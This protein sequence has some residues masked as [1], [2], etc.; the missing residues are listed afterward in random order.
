LERV[1]ERADLLSM[2]DLYFDD[3][4]RLNLEIERLRAVSSEDV[5]R[6]AGERFGP[7]NR[8][9]VSYVPEARS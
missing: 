7:D 3:P 9:V 4:G 5:R 2:F 8:A 6:F 1:G